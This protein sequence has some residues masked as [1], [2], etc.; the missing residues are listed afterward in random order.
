MKKLAALFLLTLVFGIALS[1]RDQF[2]TVQASPHAPPASMLATA[3]PTR[4]ALHNST[5]RQTS[6]KTHD[7][8]PSS[9]KGTQIDGR[10]RTDALGRLII[11]RD[12][13]NLFDYFL[14]SIG[15][16]PLEASVIRLRLYLQA[17]LPQPGEEQAIRLLGHYLDYKRQLLALERDHAQQAD[18]NAMRE[19]LQAV[20]QLRE[21][22]FDDEVH[23][24]FFAFEEAADNFTLERLAISRNQTLDAA[25]KGAAIDHLQQALPIDLRDGVIAH[26]QAELRAQTRALQA[27]GGTPTD[28]RRLRQ[29]LVGSAA[30]ARLERLDLE[31]EQWR[32]R[33]EAYRQKKTRIEGSRGLGDAD[34]RSAIARLAAEHFDE[35]ERLRLE[36]AERLLTETSG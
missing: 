16:E 19:R 6:T 22:L 13:R 12:I 33:L 36:A 7:R 31:R 3:P 23:K 9:F 10:I 15:E 25:A 34:K 30:T 24:A 28:L 21:R 11:E 32:K 26:Q 29:Q 17:Q 5:A 18:L 8:L 27:S 1:W 4:P 35:H 2:E 14:A 20:R